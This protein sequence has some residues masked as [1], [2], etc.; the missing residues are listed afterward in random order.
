MNYAV[1][2]NKKL[3]ATVY[4]KTAE[5]YMQMIGTVGDEY[6]CYPYHTREYQYMLYVSRKGSLSDYFDLDQI[7][8]VYGACGIELDAEKMKKYFQKE[9]S[10]FGNEEECEIQLHDCLGQEEL[11]VTGLLFGYPVESTVALL[12]KEIDTCGY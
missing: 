12:K 1:Q 5:E 11:A 9:L 2:K 10:Y 7:L 6:Y 8:S 3:A 4:P